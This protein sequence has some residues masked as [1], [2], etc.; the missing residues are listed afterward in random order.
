MFK[1]KADA[2]AG[3]TTVK[4]NLTVKNDDVAL[5]VESVAGTV[6]VTPAVLR[7][8]V[9]GDGLVNSADALYLLRHTF[10]AE[11]YPINQSGDMDGSKTVDSK[12]ALYLLR[13]SFDKDN[14][15][16]S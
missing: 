10:A 15:P 7:G 8:D 11:S 13:H 3:D 6:K 9:N 14:Y 16:L 5:V 4:C 1:A 2:K 12:D